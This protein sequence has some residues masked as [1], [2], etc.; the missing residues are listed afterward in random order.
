MLIP[1]FKM[2]PLSALGLIGV[3]DQRNIACSIC[4]FDTVDCASFLEKFPLVYDTTLLF[5]SPYNWHFFPAIYSYVSL[6]SAPTKWYF[7]QFICFSY[8]IPLGC[9]VYGWSEVTSSLW[10]S[11]E[12]GD[13]GSHRGF[14]ALFPSLLCPPL[15]HFNESLLCSRNSA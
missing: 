2:W 1:Y 9:P 6:P 11:G 15:Q 13:L 8:K 10:Y 7:S 3:G 5:F 12:S 4:S 14:A